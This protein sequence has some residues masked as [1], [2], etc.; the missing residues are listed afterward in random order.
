M[1]QENVK[2]LKQLYN[3]FDPFQ[4]LPADDP[5]YVDCQEVRGD[6]DIIEELGKEILYSDRMTSQLYAGHRGVGKSTELLRLKQYLEK[7]NYKVIYFAADEEDIDPEDA[8]YTD[9][10]LAC[11]RHLLEELKN[12]ADPSPLIKW[13]KDRW[14]SLKDLAL[15]EVSLDKLDVGAQISQFAKLSATLRAVPSSRQKIRDQVDIHTVSLIEALNEFIKN[16]SKK[17]TD[18]GGLVV[19][20]DNLDRIVPVVRDENTKRTNHDEIFIDRSE[21][22]RALECNVI[23]TVPISM[24]CSGQATVLEDRYGFVRVLPMIMVNTSDGKLYQDGRD[25]LKEIIE[26]RLKRADPGLSSE[27]TFDTPETLEK[28]CVISGGHVRNLM[29]MMKTAI[30]RTL[31][32]P[33]SEKSVNRAIMELRDTY[34]RTVYEEEWELLARVHI[35]REMPNKDEYR[36]LLFNRCILEYREFLHGSMKTWHDVHPLIK[37]LEQFKRTMKSVKDGESPGNEKI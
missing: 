34:S 19:I 14:Q 17:L 33:I 21:Q 15:S 22:L 35:T 10:L 12:D 2:L 25:K 16:A 32:L 5:I 26:K 37:E 28:L 36:K 8:Q 18:V 20:A 1:P 31:K 9:I 24:V 30:Q 11:T 27:S 3:L 4:P 29:L 23:Y 13:L 6:S 7:E